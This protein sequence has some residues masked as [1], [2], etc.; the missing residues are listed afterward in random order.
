MGYVAVSE[1]QAKTSPY[2]GFDGWLVVFYVYA[3]WTC[4]SSLA[5]VFA[6]M[7]FGRVATEFGT[8]DLG[9]LQVLMAVR[10]VTLLP[11]LVLTPLKHRLMPMAVIGCEWINVVVAS[12]LTPSVWTS[13]LEGMLGMMFAVAEQ[14]PAAQGFPPFPGQFAGMME[15]FV[16]AGIWQTILLGIAMTALFTWYLLASKR[17]NATYRHRLPSEDA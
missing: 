2:Y 17:V 10:V 9:G 8:F 15:L 13:M 6:F 14:G 12:I 5:A 1:Q 11:F 3:V 7:Q 16:Q 4:V